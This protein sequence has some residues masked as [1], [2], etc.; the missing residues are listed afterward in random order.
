MKP[1]ESH[2]ENAVK[3][4]RLIFL[5]IK[6][7]LVC[8]PAIAY[9]ILDRQIILIPSIV[10]I[11][12]FSYK[13]NIFSS[14]SNYNLCFIVHNLNVI[15]KLLFLRIGTLALRIKH[16]RILFSFEP[17]NTLPTFLSTDY[18]TRNVPEST[19]STSHR[20]FALHRTRIHNVLDQLRR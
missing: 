20:S 13:Y 9:T 6:C 1:L 15:N 8:D 18:D 12:Y 17:S 11:L 5:I 3:F 19:T 2:N 14:Y 10:L 16:W 7:A 4:C